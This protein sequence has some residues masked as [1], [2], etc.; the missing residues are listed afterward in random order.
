MVTAA[1]MVEAVDDLALMV[2]DRAA[3]IAKASD[4]IKGKR[5]AGR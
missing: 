4:V 5:R 2:G 3:A 1:I